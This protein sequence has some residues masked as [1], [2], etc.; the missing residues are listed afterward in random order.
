MNSCEAVE[1]LF[2]QRNESNIGFDTL[3]WA[4][5]GFRKARGYRDLGAPPSVLAGIKPS[6][7]ATSS[8]ELTASEETTRV[9]AK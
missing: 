5:A 6:V 8:S 2:F 3:L 7:V 1:W 9:I 4:E